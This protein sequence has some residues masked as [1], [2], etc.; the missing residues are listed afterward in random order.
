MEKTTKIEGMI[1][2]IQDR[3][4]GSFGA[5]HY[6]TQEGHAFTIFRRV[7]EHMYVSY[8]ISENLVREMIKSEYLRDDVMERIRINLNEGEREFLRSISQ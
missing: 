1:A 6:I 2:Y 7:R 8:S 4:D 3:L 5:R